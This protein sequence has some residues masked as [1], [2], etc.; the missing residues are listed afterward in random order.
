AGFALPPVLAGPFLGFLP[1]NL[2]LLRKDKESSGPGVPWAY[3]GD[4]GSHL[5]GILMVWYEPAR[6]LLLLPLL[7]LARVA[8]LRI[9]AGE[10][11]WVGDRRHLGHRLLD[12]GLVPK[13]AALLALMPCLPLLAV[14][15]MG[16]KVAGLACTALMVGL[17]WVAAPPQDDSQA[18]ENDEM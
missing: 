7:D 17:L 5:A 2:L 12:V 4:A 11:F 16:L 10:R 8:W 13:L 1:W 3:L 14:D 9:L 6:P 15:R 18:H